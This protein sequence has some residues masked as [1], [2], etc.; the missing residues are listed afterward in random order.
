LCNIGSIML[1]ASGLINAVINKERIS[2][3]SVNASG[4]T[5]HTC[6]CVMGYTDNYG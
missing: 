3:Q 4:D 5:R 2:A 1:D 6:Y